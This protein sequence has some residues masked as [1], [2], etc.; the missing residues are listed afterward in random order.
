MTVLWP[1]TGS[2]GFEDK[3]AAARWRYV[4]ELRSLAYTNLDVGWP[5]LGFHELLTA[6]LQMM[7][8]FAKVN[9]E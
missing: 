8:K 9:G 4:H 6:H 7:D 5:A 1:R 2:A 3:L